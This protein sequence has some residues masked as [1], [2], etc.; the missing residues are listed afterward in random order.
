MPR[1]YCLDLYLIKNRNTY[2]RH[3]THIIK[4]QHLSEILPIEKMNIKEMWIFD[5]LKN[6]NNILDFTDNPYKT[7]GIW[8]INPKKPF[9]TPL[10]KVI[11]PRLSGLTSV[12]VFATPKYI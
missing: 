5:P 11:D 10:Q 9:H 6:A 8:K 7:I 12:V 1:K 2:Y 4:G 3:N